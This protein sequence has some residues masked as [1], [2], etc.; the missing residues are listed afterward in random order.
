MKM[1]AGEAQRVT[2]WHPGLLGKY[3]DPDRIRY[4]GR[5]E[6]TTEVAERSTYVGCTG[7]FPWDVNR[8]IIFF[9]DFTTGIIY[10]QYRRTA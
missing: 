4:R 6:V 10:A 5:V 7:F 9:K 8:S 2:D 1:Y 3:G